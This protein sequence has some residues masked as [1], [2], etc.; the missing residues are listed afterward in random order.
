[1][2]DE[3]NTKLD[4]LHVRMTTMETTLAKVGDALVSIARIEE[5]MQASS[6]AVNRAFEAV[7]RV[8]DEMA[9]HEN[10]TDDRLRA[11]EE[12]APVNRLVS[13]WVLTWVVGAVALLGGVIVGKVVG[14][15]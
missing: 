15:G 12:A 4:M 9:R 2:N 5:R 11:L 14:G 8:S 10:A 3:L 13:N 1:M 6:E 7:R